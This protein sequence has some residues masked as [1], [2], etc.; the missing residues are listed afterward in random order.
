MK[1]LLLTSILSVVMCISLIAGAT[2]ALFTSESKVNIA[3]TSG[4]VNVTATIDQSSVYTKKLGVDYAQGANNMFEGVAN[5]DQDGLALSKFMPG[6]GI[7][8]NIVVKNNSDVTIKYRTIILCENDNGLFSGLEM[9]I[10]SDKKYNGVSY[11]ADWAT[12]DV[13]SADAIIPVVVELPESAGNEYQGKTCTISYKVEA[14]QGNATTEDAEDSVIYI[15]SANDL[16][17]AFANLKA[18][19]VLEFY[20]DI[21]MTGKTI[22]PVTGNK[23]FTMHGNGHTISNLESTESSLFVAHSGSSAYVFDGLNLENCSVSSTTNYAAL[24]VG[25]GDTADAITI[26]DCHVKDCTVQ[27]AKYASAFIGYT[28][29]YNVQNNGPVYSDI[30]IEDCSVAGGSIT[31]GGSVGAAIA[32]AGGNVDT[33]NIIKD[34]NVSGVALNGEDA[35]HTGVIV[36]TANVGKTIINNATYS[37]VTGNYNV[38][39][40]LFGRF[41]SGT[42]G[43][44]TVDGWNYAT[45]A[46]QLSTLLKGSANEVNVILGDGT[47]NNVLSA[48]NKTINIKGGKGAVV[49][50]TAGLSSSHDH[51]GLGGCNVTLDGV[52]VLFEDG[53][54][55]TAYINNPTITYKNCTITGQFYI[56]GD[57]SFINCTFDN[58]DEDAKSKGRYTYI[59]SGNVLVDN[60]DFYTQGH[61]L[62][63]YSDNGGG[64][65]RTLTVKNSRFHGGV[66]RTAYA[67]ANQNTAGI[68]IDGSCGANYT[69]NLEGT[70][71]FDEGFSGLWRIKAMKDGVTTTVNG[72]TYNGTTSDIYLDGVKYYKDANRNVY[73]YDGEY[74]LAN[75]ANELQSLLDAKF[76]KIKFGANIVGNVTVK[77]TESVNVEIDGNNYKFTGL[78]TVFGDAGHDRQETLKIM[79]VNFVA[80]AGAGAC[81]YSPD[82]AENNRYSYSHNVTIYNCT[83]TDIDGKVDC[84]AIRH[85]D[86]GD[87]NWTVEKCTV[88]STMHSLLQ[89]NNVNKILTVKNCTINSKNGINL[90]SCT[91]VVLEENTFNT[92]GYCVRFGVD[93]GSNP[94]DAKT[95]VFTNNTL[96]SKCDDGDAIIIFRA[97][98]NNANTTVT[99]NGN[100]LNGTIWYNDSNTIENLQTTNA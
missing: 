31:G 70:N 32:H 87:V 81:V 9:K 96:T 23:A 34:F 71:T 29:G 72:T 85:G 22:T 98:A 54:Y 25:D 45:T 94:G 43:V 17:N 74:I 82:K 84:A 67:V 63:M 4:T 93:S 56:Y 68:E 36:G 100:K 73:A 48:S 35:E 27:S 2:F 26:T 40:P 78:L 6:D 11:V 39:H 21:D 88:D 47:Y 60:C 90:N 89:V 3:V 91:N 53:G 24:F 83:F 55:Y 8:F 18:G 97:S 20:N 7:K 86:G 79:N 49:A 37:S 77:Q 15:Y 92:I 59:Y 46:S 5:F 57:T 58:D 30:T 50:I 38:S 75:S 33:T 99:M 19:N 13:G 62:I 95:F 80:K 1:K 65:D 12:L 42:T 66:G 16:V 69:L 61:A 41:V 64:G 51:L 52:S 14:V 76:T 44:L 28:A 10:G